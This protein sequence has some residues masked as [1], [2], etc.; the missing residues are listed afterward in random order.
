V[1]VPI[2]KGGDRALL[3]GSAEVRG[4]VPVGIFA[5]CRAT[6]DSGL[7][8]EGSEFQKISSCGGGGLL[9]SGCHV[10]RSPGSTNAAG[11]VSRPR[12]A[13][14]IRWRAGPVRETSFWRAR[15][16]RNRLRAFSRF[17]RTLTM[18]M[19]VEG[20][21]SHNIYLCLGTMLYERCRDVIRTAGCAFTPNTPPVVDW[22][23]LKEPC[24][25]SPRKRLFLYLS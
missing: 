7:R 5:G 24:E 19:P 10:L 22:T 1:C 16:G 4:T 9:V 23:S 6:E 25:A 12:F 11:D 18:F 14:A 8:V 15:R 17:F 13:P 20:D 3:R 21:S 2:Q